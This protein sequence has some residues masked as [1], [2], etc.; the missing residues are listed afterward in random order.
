MPTEESAGSPDRGPDP[1]FPLALQNRVSRLAPFDWYREMRQ[2]APV[3]YDEHRGEWDVFRYETVES[4]LRDPER[5]SSARNPDDGGPASMLSSDPPVHTRLRSPTEGAFAPGEVA[6]L[7]PEIRDLA[8]RLVDEAVAGERRLD[9]VEDLARWLPT[10]TIA[11]LLGVPPAERERFKEWSDTLVAGPQLTG[12]DHEGLAERQRVAQREMREYFGE[13]LDRRSVE[14]K[15]DLVSH[16]LREAEDDLTRPELRGVVQ[17]LL[18]AGNVT[19]TNLIANAVWC[20]ANQDAIRKVRADEAGL[21][22]AIEE[23]LR[24]RSPV[25]WTSRIATEPVE[26]EG[27]M[28][29]EGETIRTWL[30]A[31]NRDPAVFDEPDRFVPDRAP[32]PHLAFGQGIH[33]CLGAALAR[34]ETRIALSTLLERIEA[35]ELVETA[36]EPVAG[37]FLYGLQ[38][39]P[40]TYRRRVEVGA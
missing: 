38:H 15:D 40:I 8:E 10:M 22:S 3:R 24:Y 1:A 30:G 13:V 25:Q 17:L 34:L 12:G 2:T 19:T 4:I 14:P 35:V 33:F 23:V 6:A 5:F 39:L 18:V 11:A 36:Y 7:E 21:E 32:N 27:H 9:V 28:I 37:T 20:L 31:A 16:L 26:I 29:D